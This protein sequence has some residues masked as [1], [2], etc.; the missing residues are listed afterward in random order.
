MSTI[1]VPG[2]LL[3]EHP[4]H[5][6]YAF[7][8]N[9]R[10]YSTILGTY[11]PEKKILIPLE[12]IWYPRKGDEVIGIVSDARMSTYSVDLNAPYKGL[13]I[14]KYTE[15]RLAI[16]D[17]IEGVVRAVEGS[18]IVIMRA[19][20]LYG[21]DILDIK[22]SKIPRVIGRNNTMLNELME[23]TKS[24]IRVGMNGRIWIKGGNTVLATEAILKIQE[25][26]H[27]AGLTERIKK[28]LQEANKMVK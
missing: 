2:E 4:L 5:M 18:D 14:S 10:T 7:I 13:I 25:E 9:N 19:R 26:A 15:A 21:G 17:V 27:T 23:G 16:G 3:D 28:M 8:E 11:D 6:E 20:K 1:V 22:P 24:T 12:G